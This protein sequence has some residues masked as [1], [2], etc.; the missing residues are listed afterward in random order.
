MVVIVVVD[1]FFSE[2]TTARR[3]VAPTPLVPTF[4][5]PSF[6]VKVRSASLNNRQTSTGEESD[7]QTQIVDRLL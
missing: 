7:R 2:H 5:T 6:T 1:S 3:S 4:T